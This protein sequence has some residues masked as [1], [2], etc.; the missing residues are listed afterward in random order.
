MEN[1]LKTEREWVT[2]LTRDNGILL[3]AADATKAGAECV[4]L[5]GKLEHAEAT[6]R[7]WQEHERKAVSDC[8][9]A[10]ARLRAVIEAAEKVSEICS[11]LTRSEA[12]REEHEQPSSWPMRN[13]AFVQAMQALMNAV[14]DEV[15]SGDLPPQS[16]LKQA[17][18]HVVELRR[19]ALL[20][21]DQLASPDQCAAVAYAMDSLRDYC[22]AAGKAH[23]DSPLGFDLITHLYRQRT[24]SER[25]FGP[26]RRTA[27]I[28]DHIRKELVEIEA[29]PD[30]LTEWI[31]VVLLA[32][33]GAWRHGGTPES[34]CTTL[35]AKQ[36]KNEARTWPDWR[37]AP[38][39]KAITHVKTGVGD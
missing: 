24:F 5:A 19:L 16:L 39:G 22:E 13:P 27:G 12:H 7:H 1:A 29:K 33:D 11:S 15:R 26:A 34:I 9:K 14:K 28:L 38:D 3:K 2:G 35:Y 37:T 20:P 25:T 18:H 32:F 23:A 17:Q 21:T 31:D 8:S 30:D 4:S 6:V 10:E 36:A